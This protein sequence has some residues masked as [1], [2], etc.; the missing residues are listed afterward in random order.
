MGL[1]GK[2]KKKSNCCSIQIEETKESKK[3]KPSC[4]DIT[5]EE[6]QEKETSNET[7]S[8]FSIKE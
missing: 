3:E 4:C 6:A 7:E 2:S 1:F 5:I 8:K